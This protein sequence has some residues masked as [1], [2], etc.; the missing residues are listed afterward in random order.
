M[1]VK[2][3][4]IAWL[5][6]LVAGIS[7]SS[8]AQDYNLLDFGARGD[9]SFLN[10]QAINAA[11]TQCSEAGGGR[12]VVPAGTFVSGTVE[13]RD[14]VDLHI[15]KGG[16]LKASSNL[17]DLSRNEKLHARGENVVTMGLII[18]EGVKDVAITGGGV[19]DLS[20]EHFKIP[21]E[22]HVSGKLDKSFI[23][24]GEAYQKEGLY[25]PDG[26]VKMKQ[27]PGFMIHF[28]QCDQVRIEGITVVDSPHWAFR[29]EASKNIHISG[30]DLFNDPMI[31]NSDGIH[32]TCSENITVSDC[33]FTCGDDALIFTGFGEAETP[34]RNVVVQ[35]CILQSRSAGI[36][37]GPGE[38]DIENL[39]FSNI[40]IKESNRGIAI[41]TRDRGSVSH[42]LFSNVI[43][44]TRL[45][46]GWWGSGEPIHM[47]AIRRTEQDTLGTISHVRFN[48]VMATSEQGIVL[49]GEEEDVIRDVAFGNLKLTI[50]DGKESRTYGGNFDLRPTRYKKNEIFTH[51][52]PGM[53]C[54]NVYMLTI[55]GFDLQW[56]NNLASYF[57]HGLECEHVHGLSV[58]SFTGGAPP[59][60][61]GPVFMLR[62]TRVEVIQNNRFYHVGNVDPVRRTG[63]YAE[64]GFVSDNLKVQSPK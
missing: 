14:H 7:L 29:I 50:L 40:L 45:H 5:L 22:M 36:R 60:V 59:G 8:P 21:G 15:M 11:V 25:R 64:T 42:L 54:K 41:F 30:V 47:S 48:Q 58:E 31:P 57:N 16:I 61:E 1:H 49:Y 24:Q 37:I 38:A 9:G 19:I 55:E 44:K 28:I 35:N 43:I 56:G 12:V 13:L 10:T 4:K 32:T 2:K 33:H 39:T 53:F 63:N 3:K 27:R 34:T 62:D 20:G 26:P 51:D 18:A 46:A 6:M 52:I 23:R 17:E